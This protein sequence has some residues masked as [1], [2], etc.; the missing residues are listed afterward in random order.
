M[1]DRTRDEILRET[2]ALRARFGT[3]YDRL[4]TIL[5]EEDPEGIDLGGNT[6]EYS[7]EVSTILPRLSDC[8]SADDVQGVVSEEFR[9]WFGPA[10]VGRR[11][12]YRKVA[13]RIVTELP[14]L[15]RRA[16]SA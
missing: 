10:L 1:T 2:A 13:E 12:A 8:E 14:E 6:D 4:L 5:F 7:P 11:S 16:G 3:A 15:L 9:R